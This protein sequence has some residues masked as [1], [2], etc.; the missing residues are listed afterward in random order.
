[1]AAAYISASNGSL[2]PAFL[3]VMTLL[4]LLS[5][6]SVLL[7]VYCRA[8]LV[9]KVGPDDYL[10]VA[11]LA[12]TIGMSVMNGF[13]VSMGTGSVSLSYI[14]GSDPV[15]C[16]VANNSHVEVVTYPIC[17]WKRSSFQHSSI[18][19]ST[20]LFI[21]LQWEWSSSAFWHNTIAFLPLKIFESL[22]LE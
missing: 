18:G 19:T 2:Q 20:S 3:A 12:I 7:R 6:T 13:H 17:L 15:S 9:H 5:C 8:F 14:L 22:P 16:A 1:M 11:G 10:I 4:L 21:L